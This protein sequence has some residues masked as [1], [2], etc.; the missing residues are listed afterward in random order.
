MNRSSR[1][2]SPS[3]WLLPSVVALTLGLPSAALAQA[4]VNP[5][6]PNV[7]LLVDSSG[8]ME[9]LSSST[10]FPSCNATGTSER[11]RW[12]ELVEV[13]T[14]SIQNYHC[15]A[16]DRRSAAF[17]T[18]Y[19]LGTAQPYDYNYNVPYHRPISGTC[20][21]GPGTLPLNPYDFPTNAIGFHQYD[22]RTTACASFNQSSDGLL[23]AFLTQI[24]FG[25][26]TFDTLPDPGTGISGS[27]AD[28]DSGMDGQWS[29]FVGSATRGRPA[30]CRD[31]VDYE[32]GAR[33]AAAPPWE[34]RMIAFGSPT[35][36]LPGLSAK[37]DQIQKVLLATRPYGAT[38]I[39]GMLDDA[40]AF[41]F[42][43]QSLD[44]QNS[45]QAFG[46]YNDPYVTN[47]CRNNFVVLLS[48][49]E[50]NT[51][52]RPFCAARGN[53][54]GECPYDRPEAIAA[55]LN[56]AGV[57]VFVV[58]FAVSN[59][60]L[61][62]ATRVDCEAMSTADLS[63]TSGVCAT[64][65]DNSQLQ[66][67]CVLNRIAYNGG[68]TEAHFASDKEQLR[69]A[70]SAVLSEALEQSATSRTL[71]VFAGASSA[72]S[73]LAAQF[74]FF[75]SF[76]PR[77]FGLWTGVLE[78]QRYTCESQNGEL[79]PVAQS[80]STSSGDDFVANVN[81][82]QGSPRRFY[83]VRAA[84]TATTAFNP[85]RSV[86]P[87]ITTDVDG[88]G[89]Q[90]GDAYSG[91]AEDFVSA[92]PPASMAISSTTCPGLTAQ[93]CRD[94][95]LRWNVGLD[96]G[97]AFHRCR[98]P[99][100]SD[101]NL[102][103]D[104]YHS[105]P[106]VVGPPAEL[107]RDESYERFT[108]N[109]LE[110][111]LML[112]TSTNDGFF[113][114]FKVAS[115]SRDPADN[116]VDRLANNEL[117]SFIPPA[118]MPGILAQYPAVHQVL[119]DGAPIVRDVV[120]VPTGDA[121]NPTY[122]FERA[123]T[124]ARAGESTW[125]TV[126]VQ[127]FGGSRGGYFALDITEPEV[128][129][130][131]SGGPRFLWQLTTDASGN[132]LFGSAGA[133]PL[134]TTLFFR[135]GDVNKE[136]AVAVLPGGPEARTTGTCARN[137]ADSGAVLQGTDLFEGPRT[138]VHCYAGAGGRSLTIVRLDTGEVIR[139][140]RRQRTDVASSA[141]ADRV[142]EVR[143]LASPITGEPVAYPGATGAVADR[144]FVGDAD[145]TLW[146][147][148]LSSTDPAEWTMA[149]FL[150]AYSNQAATAGQPI[151][152]PPVL[153]TNSAGELTVAFSTGDQELLTAET[154]MRN[155]AFSLTEV[156]A[157]SSVSSR[158]NWY[159]EFVDGER[160][161]GPMTLFNGALY[162]TSFTPEPPT[163]AEV[164]QSGSSRVWGVDYVLPLDAGNRA[165]G[166]RARLPDPND[167]QA[168][169]MQS[170][171]AQRLVR[172]EGATIFGVTVAQLPTCTEEVN[173]SDSFF[174]GA[175]LRQRFGEINPG[176][177]QLI[178]QTGQAGSTIAG[179]TTRAVAVDLPTPRAA[180]RID[181]W[182]AIIQ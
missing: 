129:S 133:T 28:Y 27:A 30:N 38:P 170:M 70:L 89:V 147:L 13:L 109:H 178:M 162:F 92:T 99:G 68:T 19:S 152:T 84:S 128:R 161:T 37:N 93:Q 110:R 166:G 14:G 126:M 23:D 26:M 51:D 127:A 81:S 167:A 114:G 7:M 171:T 176:K 79:V 123:L 117:W 137:T 113:H 54:D 9:Y 91:P 36:D 56:A 136:V 181:S 165:L 86:R 124:Q 11:S 105:T 35:L 150:D 2:R 75:S 39:A 3:R 172:E 168:A 87:Q 77:P 24:R 33:N 46:P 144:V 169:L 119:L 104:I 140:F 44:P 103:G 55:R 4:D 12:I 42:D 82:G 40:E 60:D 61:N 85:E 159:T 153:S 72:Q 65:P 96:N 43:D 49:G 22:N 34:G 132:R 6:L 177:F 10:E 148:D 146:R 158:V 163:S 63:G 179:G 25:L 156:P 100:S 145:G 102:I 125:R 17:R 173:E 106:R 20:T 139:T 155:Y 94:R 80:V 41:L 160:V 48:D 73:A 131:G 15:Q 154:G 182:A 175:Q 29:Y 116:R 50:P 164:C 74:R 120:A 121:N 174:G 59:V 108:A 118:V 95:Y 151:M 76:V 69:L 180:S 101:C 97:T 45:S 1:L 53:P 71:P 52:L 18:E 141:L 64:N 134:I 16:I 66:A 58:G 67:C 111:P 138:S 149:L 107:L 157:G 98:T 8:S 88:V 115:N 21:P 130:D 57:K 90:L 112:Y 143:A 31:P 78:R 135:H 5:P 32:V 142:T 62:T 122:R 83:S 47:G